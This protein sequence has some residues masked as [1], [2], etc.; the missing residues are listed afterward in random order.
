MNR[1]YPTLI[2][3]LLDKAESTASQAERDAYTEKAEHLMTRWGI[4]AA[5][6][7]DPRHTITTDDIVVKTFHVDG[8]HRAILSRYVAA[9]V[10]RAAADDTITVL[11]TAHDK[12]GMW[13]AVGRSQDIDRVMLYVPR[14]VQQARDAWNTYRTVAT[15]TTDADRRRAVKTF[16]AAYGNRV[17]RRMRAINN[18]TGHHTA[19][20]DLVCTHIRQAVDKKITDMGITFTSGRT[21]TWDAH[22]ACHGYAAGDKASIAAADLNHTAQPALNA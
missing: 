5:Q 22:A 1:D 12:H 2:R 3:H 21:R 10:A 7:T 14:I 6:K 16:L 9:P 18:A 19:S 20:T 8:S 17:A 11:V 13:Q 15:F 4:Q